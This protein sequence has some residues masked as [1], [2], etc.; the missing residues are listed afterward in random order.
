MELPSTPVAIVNMQV[1]ADQIMLEQEYP[2]NLFALARRVHRAIGPGNTVAIEG[3]DEV[4]H[5]FNIII[6]R[7]L[8][9][10][11]EIN[12]MHGIRVPFHP[13]IDPSPLPPTHHLHCYKY[14]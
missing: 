1:Q 8:R 4:N 3:V 7:I 12:S 11:V 9:V 2:P 13:S 6:G 14:S 10:E 5:P